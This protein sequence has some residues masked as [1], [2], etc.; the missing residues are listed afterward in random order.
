[1][2]IREWVKFFTRNN[3][4]LNGKNKYTLT[5]NDVILENIIV[6]S[7]KSHSET[8]KLL[9]K[10]ETPQYNNIFVLRNKKAFNTIL[11]NIPY[12]VVICDKDGKVIK[13]FINLEIGFISN[14]IKKSYF[15]FFMVSGSINHYKISKLDRIN[16]RKIWI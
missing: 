3:L 7:E 1:M 12:D 14:Y 4:K 10:F 16:L 6:H 13:L 15:I 8:Y 11:F 2:K 9:R 5:F